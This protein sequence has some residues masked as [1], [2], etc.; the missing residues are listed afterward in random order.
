MPVSGRKRASSWCRKR[1]PRQVALRELFVGHLKLT[2]PL[3]WFS[4]FAKSFTYLGFT[5][6]LSDDHGDG[7]AV[8]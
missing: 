8:A 2:T 4:Y 1:R 3:L 7:G 5:A 6:W